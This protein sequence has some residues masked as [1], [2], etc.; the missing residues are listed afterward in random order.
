METLTTLHLSPSVCLFFFS[1]KSS[2]MNVENLS[3][4]LLKLF[5]MQHRSHHSV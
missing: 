5:T 2:L 4:T 1:T 3:G